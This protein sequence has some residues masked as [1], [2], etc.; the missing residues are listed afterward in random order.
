MRIGFTNNLTNNLSSAPAFGDALSTKQERGYKKL[1]NDIKEE[2]GY[3]NGMDIVKFYIPSLPSNK[4][5]DTG[6]GKINSKEAERAYEMA[7]V[8]YNATGIKVMPMGPLTDKGV[9]TDD[10]Y[11]GAYNRGALAVGEDAINITKLTEDSYGNILSQKDAIEV[12]LKHTTNHDDTSIIDF[13]TTLGWQNQNEYPINKTLR[14]AFTNFKNPEHNNPGL[15]ALREEFEAFKNQKTPVDYDDV[16][17]RLAL[18]P[19]LKDYGTARVDFFRGF[20]SDPNIR[21]QKMPEYNRLKEQYKDEIE[22]FKFKQFLGHKAIADGKQIINSKGMDVIG[23]CIIGFSWPE[24]QVFPDAFLED[25]ESGWGLPALNYYDLIDK[26]D[27]AAHK[28]LRTKV[29]HYLTNYDGIRFDVGWQY[30]NPCLLYDGGHTYKHLDAGNKITDFIEQIATEIKGPDFDQRKLMYECD[31]GY[32]D[33][34]IQE[35]HI[36]DKI[37]HMKGL[38]IL[39]TEDEKNDER[40]VG[41]GN[42]AYIR[43]NLRLG[44]DNVLLGT[45]NHDKEGVVNCAKDRQKSDE[46]VGALMRVFRL[47]P[48]DGVGSGWR[49]LKD[50]NNLLSHIKKYCRARFAEVKTMKNTFVQFF[51]MLGRTEKTD[52]HTGGRGENSQV[53]Y[54]HRL[55]RHYEENF[56][57][58]LQDGVGYNAADIQKFRMEHDG[59]KER[60]PDLYERAVKYAAYLQHKGGIYTREQ[61]DNNTS[62]ADLDIDS[63]TLEEINRL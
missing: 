58:A 31:A 16:Y 54:K 8:Y 21:A 32:Y 55:E 45:N 43:E 30:M 56:H 19:Y 46:H 3:G 40:N 4:F 48:Q 1:L 23:D 13:E 34:P 51:D 62:R 18:Y 35:K 63:L 57:R 7:N 11:V 26:N 14:T 33:F 47:R 17:T 38:A 2:Q 60:R 25:A 6:I 15:Q 42:A 41:W 20:D 10:H 9:Y 22:F 29:A 39:S 61:A 12:V 27:S 28:L 24:K 36:Q 52:Y 53:D 37:H 50:D 49:D 59:T 5:N 44:N